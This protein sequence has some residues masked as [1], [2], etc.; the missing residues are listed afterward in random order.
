MEPQFKKLLQIGIIVDDVDKCVKNYEEHFGMGPWR[1]TYM[2]KE[3]FPKLM[4]DG[5]PTDMANKCAFCDA[6]G[7][8]L[9]LIEPL[10]PS[11]YKTWLDEHGPGIHHIAVITKDSF[12]EVMDKCRELT[13]KDAWLHGQEPDIGMDFAYLD[14]TKQLGIF[15]EIYNEDRSTQPGHDF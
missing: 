12:G 3:H 8:E 11:A 9:E 1:I 5:K 13:G 2:D 14:L 7:I 4:A 15:V 10:A 6:Y